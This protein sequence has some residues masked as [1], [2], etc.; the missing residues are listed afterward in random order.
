M[1]LLI[2]YSFFCIC[3]ICILNLF[4]IKYVNVNKKNL[5]KLYCI[6]N[7][8]EGVLNIFEIVLGRYI[9]CGINLLFDI[10]WLDI[11]LSI[12]YIFFYCYLIIYWFDILVLLEYIEMIM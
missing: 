3:V 6:F 5:W 4:V 8:L 1:F 2:I 10:L 12:D 7:W 9:I 11:F